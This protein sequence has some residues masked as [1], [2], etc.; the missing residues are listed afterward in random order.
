[1]GR[2]DRAYVTRNQVERAEVISRGYLA[3]DDMEGLLQWMNRDNLMEMSWFRM[4]D[5][6]RDILEWT[7]MQPLFH[8]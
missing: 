6:Q 2:Y 4:S 1:M 3:H 7:G 8:E 5:T